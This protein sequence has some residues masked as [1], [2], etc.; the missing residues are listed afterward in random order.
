MCILRHVCRA[1]VFIVVSYVHSFLPC[2]LHGTADIHRSI[3]RAHVTNL[4]CLTQKVP[5][6]ARRAPE[7]KPFA[8]SA[9]DTAPFAYVDAPDNNIGDA[10]LIALLPAL[11]GMKHLTSLSLYGKGAMGNVIAPRNIVG[12][13]RGVR[14]GKSAFQYAVHLGIRKIKVAMRVR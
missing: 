6:V 1:R 14:M 2:L 5:L 11:T 10:G 7:I 12:R 4:D 9:C 13:M 8:A 3:Y